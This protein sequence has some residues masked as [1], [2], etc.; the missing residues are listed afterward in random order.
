MGAVAGGNSF[1][2]TT[3][4]HVSNNLRSGA[5]SSSPGAMATKRTSDWINLPFVPLRR[6]YDNSM[7]HKMSTFQK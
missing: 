7:K 3:Q 5:A 2:M 4:I 6:Q 1:P